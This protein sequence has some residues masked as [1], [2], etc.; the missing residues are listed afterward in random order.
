MLSAASG[1]SS[2]WVTALSSA[3]CKCLGDGPFVLA[4]KH[5][6][7]LGLATTVSTQPCQ[8]RVTGAEHSDHE[9]VKKLTA[10]MATLRYGI[11]VS[12]WRR[13]FP[14]A[15]CATSTKQRYSNLLAQGQRGGVVGLRMGDC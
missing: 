5:L 7:G 13:A 2:G 4:G 3:P 6:F 14:C 10:G 11:W 9:R 15:G 8:C 12:A 1:P